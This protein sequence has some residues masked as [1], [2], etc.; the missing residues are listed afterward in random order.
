MKEVLYAVEF[1]S[2]LVPP[3]I[4]IMLVVSTLGWCFAR[5]VQFFARYGGLDAPTPTKPKAKAK[6]APKDVTLDITQFWDAVERGLMFDF[7]KPKSKGKHGDYDAETFEYDDNPFF[8]DFFVVG[9]DGE[10]EIRERKS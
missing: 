10:L 7:S 8:D 6:N 1:F 5:L 9:D 4:M 2:V 3:A